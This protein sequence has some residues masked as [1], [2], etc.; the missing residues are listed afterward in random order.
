M[1]NHRSAAKAARQAVRRE[2]RNKAVKSGVKTQVRRA[3]AELARDNATASTEAV[4]QAVKAL[5]RAAKKG[6]LHPRNIA[7][8]KSRLVRKLNAATAAKPAS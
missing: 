6:I 7:R 2:L 4:G 3:E 5:D 1:A 8:R